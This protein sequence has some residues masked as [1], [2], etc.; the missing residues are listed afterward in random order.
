MG[1]T[2][3]QTPWLTEGDEKRAA[4]RQ[5]FADIAPSYDLVNSLMCFR[6]HHRWRTIAVQK[7]NLK[8]GEHVLDL[9]CG[10]GDFL[11]PIKKAVGPTGSVTGLDFCGPMLAVA[12]QKFQNSVNL[13]EADACTLP[14]A[15]QRFDA[16]TVG[17]G[18]RNVPDLDQALREAH[19]VLKPGG[20]FVSLDMARPRGPLGKI[21]EW[22]FHTVVP[23]LGRLF[24][25]TTAY[26]YLPQSTL[27]F[28]SREEL[29]AK[30]EAAGFQ[31]VQ[32]K[33]LFFG[34]ICL[35]W[36]AKK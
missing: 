21:S 31:N 3:K 2:A 12:R 24:G 36:G 19:R 26:Q 33:D 23:A 35:H 8:P 7:I 34:N 17:W 16:A 32:Y 11:S 15:D 18:L 13:T 29:K 14:L 28:A 6:L 4:V 20:R 27:K 5:M 22:V 30:M 10:T 1:D 9:C 25:K